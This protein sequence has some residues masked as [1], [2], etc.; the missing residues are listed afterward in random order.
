MS[1]NEIL[2]GALEARIREL[3]A[4]NKSL[5]AAIE[6]YVEPKPGTQYMHR[7]ALLAAKNKAKALCK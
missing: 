4:A 1:V 7:S 6:Q 5:I 3:A 2:I